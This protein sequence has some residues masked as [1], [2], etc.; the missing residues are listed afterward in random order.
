MTQSLCPDLAAALRDATKAV[1]ACQNGDLLLADALWANA[2]V[3]FQR[4]FLVCGDDRPKPGWVYSPSLERYRGV[5][6]IRGVMQNQR[7]E[8]RQTEEQALADA[9]ALCAEYA[10]EEL[11]P[12]ELVERNGRR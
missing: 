11:T 3:S 5:V 7:G 4:G 9:R 6:R 2:G 8:L 12:L 1:E 10:D